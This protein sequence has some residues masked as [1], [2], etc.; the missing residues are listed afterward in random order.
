[1]CIRFSHQF[2]SKPSQT[3]TTKKNSL[4][5]GHD[6]APLQAASG[7]APRPYKKAQA[8]LSPPHKV[9]WGGEAVGR[10]RKH[11]TQRMVSYPTIQLSID[12]ISQPAE[13]QT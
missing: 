9:G 3:I 11:Y 7:A 8:L 6:Q 12:E 5:L 13:K 1:M 2:N 10:R 4:G